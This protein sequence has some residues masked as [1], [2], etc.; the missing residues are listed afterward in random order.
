VIIFD[1][2]GEMLAYKELLFERV[3]KKYTGKII[4]IF[5]FLALA[6]VHI[7]QAI[8]WGIFFRWTRIMPTISES[9]YFAAASIT[10]VGYGAIVLEYTW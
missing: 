1:I 9:I 6:L 7:T 10:T 2:I 8:A 4:L 3:V 5:F